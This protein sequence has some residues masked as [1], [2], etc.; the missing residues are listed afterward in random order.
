MLEDEPKNLSRLQDPT[1]V[2]GPDVFDT[3]VEISDR[4]ESL[5]SHE[6]S[7]L[8]GTAAQVISRPKVFHEADSVN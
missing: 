3:L 4:D 8:K 2:G 5:E 1:F 7:G 6:F